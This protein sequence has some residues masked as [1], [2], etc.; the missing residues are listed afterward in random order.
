V[1]WCEGYRRL[2]ITRSPPGGSR[3]LPPED[4]LAEMFD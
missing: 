1:A 3:G 2:V 4:Q